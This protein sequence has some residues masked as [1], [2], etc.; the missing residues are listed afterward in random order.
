MSKRGEEILLSD[1][2]MWA[3]RRVRG[4]DFSFFSFLLRH[5]VIRDGVFDTG[6]IGL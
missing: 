5:I 2:F 1:R 3:A 6:A 4:V